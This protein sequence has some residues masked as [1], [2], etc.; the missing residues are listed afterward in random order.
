MACIHEPLAEARARILDKTGHDISS[1]R[2][3]DPFPK[4]M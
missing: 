4:Q 1:V 2:R 3:L